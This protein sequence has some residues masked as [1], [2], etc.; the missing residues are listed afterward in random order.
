M[1]G[2]LDSGYARRETICPVRAHNARD[3]NRC[4]CPNSAL[5]NGWIALFHDQSIRYKDERSRPCL[6]M[7]EMKYMRHKKKTEEKKKI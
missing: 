4:R 2:Q 7:A 1:A 6:S 3:R 5:D